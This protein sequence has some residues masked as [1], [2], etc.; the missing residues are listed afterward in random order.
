MKSAVIV[1]PGSNCDRD[2]AVALTQASGRKTQM[3]WHKDA[4]LP[5]GLD[6]IAI[7]G[8]FSFGDYLR[9][10]AIAARAPIMRAVI[11]FANRGG[12]VLGVCNGFQVLIEAGLLP[13]ALMRNQTLKF[14]CRDVHLSVETTDSPF[15]SAYGNHK[16]I[17]VPIAHHDGA[18]IADADLLAR[19]QAEDRI[20]FRYVD[21]EG[22]P[23]AAANPNGSAG[24]IAG[25]LSANRRVLGMMPHPERLADP[26]LGGTDGAALFA[27]LCD[28]LTPA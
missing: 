20:A 28:A 25:V 14:V 16:V 6:M 4:A 21:A 18:Y 26:A 2:M 17:T 19:L 7:P 5:Q 15:T 10:G 23:T 11:D 3:V 24:N 1:F 9:C 8:G 22:Q 13:G 12:L 27:S